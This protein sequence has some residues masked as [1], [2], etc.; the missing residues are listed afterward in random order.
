MMLDLLESLDMNISKCIDHFG[1]NIC[2][3]EK[4]KVARKQ[5]RLEKTANSIFEVLERSQGDAD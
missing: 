2:H 3:K 4:A 1:K 5:E